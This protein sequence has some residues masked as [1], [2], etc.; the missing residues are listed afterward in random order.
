MAFSDIH[1]GDKVGFF[2]AAAHI[3]QGHYVER[4]ERLFIINAPSFFSL[5]WRA[6]SPLLNKNTRQKISVCRKG[7]VIWL[8]RL[9][10]VYC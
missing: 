1:G 9:C 3:T 6:A 7:K 2:K 5:V 10:V 4:C 8:V